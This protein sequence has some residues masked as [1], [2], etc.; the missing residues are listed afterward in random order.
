MTGLRTLLPPLPPLSTSRLWPSV[1]GSMPRLYPP[2]T[3]ELMRVQA[4][5]APFWELGNRSLVL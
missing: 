2:T 3:F 4:F 5:A 1:S